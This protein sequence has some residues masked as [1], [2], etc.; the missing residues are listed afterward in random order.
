MSR[1]DH[2]QA[3][4]RT[5]DAPYRDPRRLLILLGMICQGYSFG[6]IVGPAA[7]A[8]LWALCLRARREHRALSSALESVLTVAGLAVAFLAGNR[9]GTNRLVFLG[10]GLVVFQC[11]YLL[12]A[13][14]RREK[15]LTVAVALVHLGV[16][17][18]VVVDYEFLIVL[19]AALWLLPATL[20]QLEVERHRRLA[21]GAAAGRSRLEPVCLAVFIVVFFLVFPRFRFF[22]YAGGLGGPGGMRPS[23]EIEMAAGGGEGG[24]RL[25]FRI[26]GRD[27]RYLKRTALDLWNG[28]SWSKSA[29]IDKAI[30]LPRGGRTADA[31]RRTVRVFT[32]QALGNAV[33]A[34]GRVVD[35]EGPFLQRP[36]IAEHGG[37]MVPFRRRRNL[38]YEYWTRFDVS[39]EMLRD[40]ERRRYLQLPEVSERLSSW[41][42]EQTG[43]LEP[44]DA[45]RRLASQLR[46]NHDYELGAPN[47]DR[48]RPVEDFVF[49]NAPGHCER[50]ASALA[51]LLRVRGIPAR[52]ALGWLPLERNDLGGF[53]NVRTRHG[54][55]WTEA[56]LPETGWTILDATPHG[57]GLTAESRSLGL[58]VY[59]WI[60]YV[61]YAKIVEFGAA[62]QS[63]LAR[64]A[65]DAARRGFK[66]AVRR[67][68][69]LL[70]GFLVVALAGLLVR[71]GWRVRTM[72]RGQAA[73]TPVEVASHFYGRMLRVLS[74][75][76][77]PRSPTQTPL[78]YLREVERAGH[79]AV[80]DV[81]R[82]TA[83]FCDVRYGRRPLSADTRRGIEEAQKRID[84]ARFNAGSGQN[85]QSA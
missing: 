41:V 44:E 10:N 17:A 78:E 2:L 13:V 70:A 16:G 32:V 7:Y 3:A 37:V 52:V 57:S 54:H 9:F 38:T 30:A 62:D 50:F 5:A 79:P 6:T 34:D 59:E 20:F 73:A 36:Y 43:D 80:E 77:L 27:V 84:D 75:Q 33:P 35:L 55:A 15:L 28:R 76:N 18:Q 11:L 65:A 29:W 39:E 53:F 22:S 12:R 71:L 14:S 1:E 51:V 64:F 56:W 24:D 45:A 23:E 8:A 48:I 68:P 63:G 83:C 47:L 67:V 4:A 19:A 81:R 61:W 49:S 85:P 25:L 66:N 60:E 58:T 21:G 40:R 69:V 26:E 46:Q 31:L 74:R 82:I 72:K 42:D